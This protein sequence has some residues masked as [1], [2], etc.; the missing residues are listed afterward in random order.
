[1]QSEHHKSLFI[2][3]GLGVGDRGLLTHTT[4]RHRKKYKYIVKEFDSQML[5][6][7]VVLFFSS[8]L[9]LRHG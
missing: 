6:S 5:R 7:P 1:M 2:V 4:P 3:L 8:F 9:T